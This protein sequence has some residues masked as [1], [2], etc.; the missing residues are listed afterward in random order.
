MTTYDQRRQ[1]ESLDRD[2]LEEYQLDR[3]NALLAEILPRNKF[4]SE[5]LA[6][7]PKQLES[8]ESLKEL[9]F[10]TKD[11]LLPTGGPPNVPANLTHPLEHYVRFHQT[12]GT[13]GRPL[14]VFDTADDW[15]WW[16][17]C[18]QFVLDAA[19]ISPTDRAMLAFSFGPFIGFWSAFDALVER[20]VLVA[21]GGGMSSLA[22]LDL[23]E[24]LA[25]TVLFCT[26]TYALH[27]AE[28]ARENQIDLHHLP[29]QKIFV[30]GEPGGSVPAIRERIE[31][32]WNAKLFDHSGASEIGPWGYGDPAARGLYVMECEF[33]AE[34][35]GVETGEPAEE[36][37]LSHLVLTTLG[38][39][40]AP[41]IRYRTGDLVR[42][43]WNTDGPCRFV[44]LEGGVL[45]RADDMLVIR[46]VNI[47]PTSIE[48]IL[49]SFPEVVEY[50][51]TARK[52]GQ[53][54]TVVI[55]VEDHLE[56]TDRI[57]AELQKRLGLSIEVHLVP[58]M[59]L[60][61]FEG[62]GRRFVDER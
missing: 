50:R 21:P 28:V 58:P 24:R 15:R 10:T 31:S 34:F 44:L 47:Y 42:P 61:R 59:T 18:W 2:A 49:R 32:T 60:P 55:E 22:R 57:A 1:L 16:M 12:S 3:L 4:Y 38:R 56:R 41:L 62:K 20:G 27:L 39:A 9:P 26:P 17:N 14:P 45:G 54:D 36:G 5:K 52:R 8:F 53:M 23:M 19:G 37:E 29:V 7:S 25:A 30:A 48:Q 11:E 51:L 46:G 33:L 40:G 13:R 6:G 43:R 35:I